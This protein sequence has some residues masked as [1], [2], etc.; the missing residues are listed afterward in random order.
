MERESNRETH[1]MA[2]IMNKQNGKLRNLK[3]IAFSEEGT[4]KQKKKENSFGKSF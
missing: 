3:G 2:R 4:K 1:D